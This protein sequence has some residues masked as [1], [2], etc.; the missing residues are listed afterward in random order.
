M[1]WNEPVTLRGRHAVLEPLSLDH[2]EGLQEA[3]KDGELWKLWYTRIP[4][5]DQMAANIKERLEKQAKGEMLSWAV[6]DPDSS[7]PIGV[8]S[9]WA[10]D[11]EDRRV[12]IG[13]TWYQAGAQRTGVNTD[14]KLM[15]LGRAFE[16][17]DCIAVEFRTSTFNHKSRTAIERLGA[18]LD[19]VLR[20]HKRH[21]DGSL[22]DTC[23][24]SIVSW[25]WPAVRSNLEFQLEKF[26]S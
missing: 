15:L 23:V 13:G 1:G 12:E 11:A 5:P 2:C 9:Y 14:C 3:V 8:T 22:R 10:I 20:S 19:G 7:D 16:A 18:K 24:Y 25:E 6:L 26:R 21:A 17:L 4:S